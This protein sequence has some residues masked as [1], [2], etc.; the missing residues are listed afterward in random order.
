MTQ[1]R[2]TGE[3]IEEDGELFL[4]FPE[5]MLTELGWEPGDTIVWDFPDGK[6]VVIARK[7][8]PDVLQPDQ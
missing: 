8:R 7:A 1:Q 4:V 5:E 2:W 6:N 3:V